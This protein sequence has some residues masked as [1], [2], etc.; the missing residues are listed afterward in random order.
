MC[1]GPIRRGF[2]YG[3]AIL[4]AVGVTAAPAEQAVPSS[5]RS[6][7]LAVGVAASGAERGVRAQGTVALGGA[8]TCDS[9]CSVS[10]SCKV[11]NCVG[12]ACVET[13]APRDTRCN[14]DG[15]FC[16]DDRC[17][18]AGVCKARKAATSGA[19]ALMALNRC[20]KEC[21]NIAVANGPCVDLPTPSS[22][23]NCTVSADCPGVE[24]CIPKT[25]GSNI[26]YC[27]ENADQCQVR[28][29]PGQAGNP[30]QGR[31]CTYPSAAC[32]ISGIPC[33]MPAGG[34]CTPAATH[35]TC[36]GVGDGTCARTTAANCT[37]GA[38]V[39]LEDPDDFLHVCDATLGCPHYSSGISGTGTGDVGRVVPPPRRCAIGGG[40][41]EVDADCWPRCNGGARDGQS[42]DTLSDCPGA[43]SCDAGGTGANLCVD[44]VSECSGAGS[45]TYLGD[46]YRFSNDSAPDT[47][48]RLKEFRFRGGGENPNELVVFD[49]Y[50]H[51]LPPVLVDSLPVRL[52]H[53]G[54]LDYRVIVDCH[55]D[56]DAT[57]GAGPFAEARREL[58]FLIPSEGFVVARARRAPEPIRD[59]TGTEDVNFHWVVASGPQVGGNDPTRMVAKAAASAGALDFAANLTA[60]NVLSF[61]LLGETVPDPLYACCDAATGACANTRPWECR[62][63]TGSGAAC[64]NHRECGLNQVQRCGTDQWRGPRTAEEFDTGLCSGSPCP[65]C[66]GTTDPSVC[67]AVCCG[68]NAPPGACTEVAGALDCSSA[69][70]TL[71]GFGAGC[72]PNRCP[73]PVQKGVDC[74]ADSYEC[75]L[76]G[77]PCTPGAGACANGAEGTCALV[78]TGADAAGEVTQ[79]APP[80][81]GQTDRYVISG[82]T[83]AAT[84]ADDCAYD[85]SPG[86]YEV[87]HTQDCTVLTLSYC[88]TDPV[89]W[90]AIDWLE[91]SCPC[92]PI[93]RVFPDKSATGPQAGFGSS[94]NNAHCCDDGN[95]SGQFTLRQGTYVYQ[96]LQVG[97]CAATG[98]ECSADAE[99]NDPVVPGMVG[100]VC[101]PMPPDYQ[102]QIYAEACPLAACC[103]ENQAALCRVTDRFACED[104]GGDWLGDAAPPVADCAPLP[105]GT[106]GLGSCCAGPGLCQDN[107]GGGMAP[108]ACTNGDYHGGT[109][110]DDSPCP[111]CPFEDPQHCQTMNATYIFPSDRAIG[112]RRVDDFR[113]DGDSIARVCWFPCWVGKQGSG[114]GTFEC[115]GSSG[116]TK[117]PDAFRAVIYE[118]DFG[119]PGLP[120]AGV[121]MAGYWDLIPDAMQPSDGPSGTSRC[122][123]YTAPLNPPA[124][125]NQGDCY[126]LEITGEGEVQTQGRCTV[127]WSQSFDG[128]NMGV[129]DTNGTFEYSDLVSQEYAWCLSSGIQGASNPPV[130]QD[131]GCG[132]MPAACCKP[133]PVC[134]DTGT[135]LQC[136]GT[137]VQPLNG[138]ALPYLTCSQLEQQGGCPSPPNDGCANATVVCAGQT[139]DP[140]LGECTNN[141]AGHDLD[142]PCN[143]LNPD[144]FLAAVGAVCTPLPPGRDAYRCTVPTDNRLATTDGPQFG[145]TGCADADAFQ[146]D[147]WFEY[148]APC[149]GHMSI[150]MCRAMTY[151][152]MLQVFSSNV[153]NEACACAF[154][155]GVSRACSDDACFDGASALELSVVGNACYLIRVGGYSALGS[156]QDAGQNVSE[157]E[158]GVICDAVFPPLPA[159]PPHDR[160]T[161]RY[162][163]FKPDPRGLVPVSYGVTRVHPG[164]CSG[165][166]EECYSN[167]DCPGPW[168]YCFASDLGWVDTPDANG[169][170]RIVRS[171]TVPTP[172]V[173]TEPVVHVGDCEIFP[174]TESADTSLRCSVGGQACSQVC[175]AGQCPPGQGECVAP[176]PKFAIWATDGAGFY[177]ADLNVVT[178][179]RPC[180]KRW[181]DTVGSFD[182][183]TQQWDAPNGVVNTN[184]FLAAL[185]SFQGL[186]TAPHVTVVDVVGAGL[187]GL[188]A[189]INE[190]GNIGDV[191]SL[192]KAF[193]G[194]AY[195]AYVCSTSGHGCSNLGAA[196]VAPG[197]GTCSFPGTNCP[198]CPP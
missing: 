42:C 97:R 13:N 83:A 98:F 170:A 43:T 111:I 77:T 71:L 132:N 5:A 75:T 182:G 54:I 2:V 24:S 160:P 90:S 153:A 171:P 129:R 181:G 146:A 17:D 133:G 102:M 175:G 178:T 164:R 172:R 168:G 26:A 84:Y 27:V 123:R 194:A 66:A 80:T 8:C 33:T 183:G 197:V 165:T 106:C 137:Q 1:V 51:S 34:E 173:W 76:T 177:T 127:S 185:Q 162:I 134:D 57:Q 48:L 28:A 19:G 167:S 21:C 78:C 113:A 105:D 110:C 191:F 116:G 69:G 10:G 117:P 63:C 120:I 140:N 86:W 174:G 93:Q 67:P 124:F 126:W 131:G 56:C 121:P 23:Q 62:L 73:Q 145:V 169:F 99:C 188:E 16:T 41:C 155:P 115:S 122:W 198:T 109:R 136:V 32:S 68:A 91:L 45:Y 147:I 6:P 92:D 96:V 52:L 20:A 150:M 4:V 125:V 163:S 65:V 35:G 53:A 37:A 103:D 31:C 95:W 189:C 156:E 79:I 158:I 30:P 149:T 14:V 148:V 143:L 18:E 139:P 190:S 74:C 100:D 193:Q 50:D 114:P 186:P 130:S 138:I 81:A 7:R 47:Y 154:S 192:I 112:E 101:R 157:L 15:G 58:P 72:E 152:S 3:S 108:A 107:G 187:P 59:Y 46:D 119:L 179:R 89:R 184:D 36:T 38:W 180:P 87:I 70:G 49:F 39:R 135:Y 144:C 40:L 161:S 166:G 9:E 104:A 82:S 29:T 11:A 60:S 176:P 159:D 25:T 151:D 141:P 94:C 128:N 142:E 196:C 12:G 61:E 118:D 88:G 195:P 64:T 85:P 44:D 22:H 55:P